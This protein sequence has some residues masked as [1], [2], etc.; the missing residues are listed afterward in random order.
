MLHDH[1]YVYGGED[2]DNVPYQAG[3]EGVPHFFYGGDTEVESKDIEYGL[4]AADH[5]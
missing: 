3:D 1:T 2:A 4:A 5:Y